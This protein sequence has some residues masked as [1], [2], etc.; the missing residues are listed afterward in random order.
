MIH[1][2]R[3]RIFR[4][5]T[6]AVVVLAVVTV[7]C[8]SD[9]S[10]GNAEA[11]GYAPTIDAGA[12]TAVVDNPYHPLP[13]GATWVY[14]VTTTEGSTDVLDIEVIDET[15]LVMGVTATVVRATLTVDGEV[16]ERTDSWFAQ[17]LDGT[18]WLFGEVDESYAEGALEERTTWEA[19]VDGAQP[20]VIMPAKPAL[21]EDYRVGWVE[22]EMEERGR[23]IAADGSADVPAGS[24]S[25]L[26]VIENWTDLEPEVIERKQYAS[27]I[28]L[29]FADSDHPDTDTLELTSAE[30]PA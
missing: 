10:S 14:D 22:G 12:F 25:D 13:V 20:G 18:V 7:S 4:A 1:T 16:E 3:L 2:H 11:A 24:F 8:G 17:D 30:V 15:K 28:G 6:L 21:D 5:P 19:G 23:V 27:G 26:R 9:S 29:V